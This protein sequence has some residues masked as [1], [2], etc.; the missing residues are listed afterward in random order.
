MVNPYLL[1]AVSRP[2]QFNV[3]IYLSSPSRQETLILATDA[4]SHLQ[5][6]IHEEYPDKLMTPA[7]ASS[8]SSFLSAL[9]ISVISLLTD[10]RSFTT[11]VLGEAAAFRQDPVLT[12]RV[13]TG[14]KGVPSFRSSSFLS[15]ARRGKFAIYRVDSDRF[16]NPNWGGEE[17]KNTSVYATHKLAS[18]G[19]LKRWHTQPSS[20]PA[21]EAAASGQPQ[22]QT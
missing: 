5:A 6:V 7:T 9:F 19:N 13:A 20:E 14:P 12:N 22:R 3:F 2:R 16:L 8:S 21:L 17:K 11:G 4:P 15:R 18:V 1:W 10:R